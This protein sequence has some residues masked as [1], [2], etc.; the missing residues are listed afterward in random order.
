MGIASLS[1]ILSSTM[2]FWWFLCV[3]KVNVKRKVCSL[4]FMTV[5]AK[6]LKSLVRES[7][8]CFL[9]SF[10]EFQTSANNACKFKQQHHF[11]TWIKLINFLCHYLPFCKS[12]WTGQSG[13]SNE[14]WIPLSSKP[15]GSYARRYFEDT[16]LFRGFKTNSWKLHIIFVLSY[17]FK[18][19][20][21]RC[22]KY[23]K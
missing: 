19:A 18:K 17:I 20:L 3:K 13:N 5:W 8:T 21:Q 11:P 15:R 1:I 16:S 12:D 23:S 10:S 9:F 7:Y 14:K 2:S 22:Y 4:F 6:T